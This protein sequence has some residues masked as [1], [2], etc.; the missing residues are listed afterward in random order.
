MSIKSRSLPLLLAVGVLILVMVC[1]GFYWLTNRGPLGLMVGGPKKYPVATM[2]IPKNVPLMASILVEPERLEN[3]AKEKD[4]HDLGGALHSW[5]QSLLSNFGLD[6]HKDI[7]PWVGEE[8]TFAI[9]NV[10]LDRDQS[11]GEL[12]GKLIVIA[13]KD[14]QLSGEFWEFFWEN[15]SINGVDVAID[16]YR[17]VDLV[18]A[19]NKENL[20]VTAMVGDEFVL[21]ANDPKVIR[22]AINC[23]QVGELN[24]KESADYQRALQELKRGRIALVYSN[25]PQL[26][27]WLGIETE[28]V[29][30][31][32]KLNSL[33]LK[34]PHTALLIS[35]GLNDQGLLAETAL[36]IG[37]ASVESSILPTLSQPV[38]ALNFLPT[39]SILAAGSANLQQLGE[40]II[41]EGSEIKGI[42][43]FLDQ[44]LANLQKNWGIDLQKDIL[45]WVQGE[46]AL[47]LF[48]KVDRAELEWLFIAEKSENTASA[49]EHLDKIAAEKPYSIGS[50]TIN[51]Q[52]ITAWTKLTAIPPTK[53]SNNSRKTAIKTEVKGAHATVGNYEIFASSLEAMSEALEAQETG[54]LLGSDLFQESIAKLPEP[55]EGYFYIDWLTNQGELE[56][57]IPVLRFVELAAK[58]LFSQLKTI[59]ISSTGS[60]QG[61]HHAN[62][63]LKLR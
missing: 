55:N 27:H 47:A 23:V 22:E 63:L 13:T 43:E 52:T 46:Y 59:V 28:I 24:L 11:N 1:G 41:S 30:E 36:K 35:L 29:K 26:A 53:S 50:F 33:P 56:K 8:L 32:D 44:T 62:V 15:Q 12:A 60:D 3:L 34:N 61:I 10:D 14:P 16:S 4:P 54:S 9:T 57:Q 37:N 42:S 5:E 6:Y 38:A 58:P 2:F 17:G 31:S 45:Q 48:P 39:N 19:R 51:N 20:P 40:T 18:Y 49:I 7:E 25:L 21:L